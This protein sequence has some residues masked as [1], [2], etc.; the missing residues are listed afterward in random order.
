MAN[1]IKS[2]FQHSVIAEGALPEGA[3]N[4]G[5]AA[6]TTWAIPNAVSDAVSARS[7]NAHQLLLPV[8]SAAIPGRGIVV[9]LIA[10]GLVGDDIQSVTALPYAIAPTGNT[11]YAIDIGLTAP[12]ILRRTLANSAITTTLL[13]PSAGTREKATAVALYALREPSYYPLG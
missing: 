1:L 3:T 13:T 5:S 11:D 9:G 6:Q 2:A 7:G 8:N 4:L 12:A 10:V